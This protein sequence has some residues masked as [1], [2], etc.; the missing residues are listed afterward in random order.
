MKCSYLL[1]G[2]LFIFLNPQWTNDVNWMYIRCYYDSSTSQERFMF[3]QLVACL[4][5][6]V[7]YCLVYIGLISVN[8]N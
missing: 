8:A 1:V 5:E 7:N 6:L 3:V 2:S 4:L